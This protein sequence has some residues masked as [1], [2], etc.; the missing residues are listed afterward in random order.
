MNLKL[1]N[2]NIFPIIFRKLFA[3]NDSHKIKLLLIFCLIALCIAL[4]NGFLKAN[5]LNI[6]SIL[7]IVVTFIGTNYYKDTFYKKKIKKL[8]TKIIKCYPNILEKLCK[9]N[10][11]KNCNYYRNARKDFFHISNLILQ[12][13]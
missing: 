10:K 1:E 6:T 7:I 4:I 12:K 5:I 8:K 13:S 9:D 3:L 2:I 11:T